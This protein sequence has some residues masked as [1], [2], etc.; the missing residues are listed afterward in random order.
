M[1]TLLFNLVM[2]YNFSLTIALD[3][4]NNIRK[5]NLAA[6]LDKPCF[7]QRFNHCFQYRVLYV[8]VY[9]IRDFSP[10]QHKQIRIYRIARNVGGGKH[11]RIDL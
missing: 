2:F 4:Q 3:D 1:I 7:Q 11:W 9:S 6:S 8:L 5:P 10:S